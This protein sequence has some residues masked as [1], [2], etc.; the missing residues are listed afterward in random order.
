MVCIDAVAASER[1]ILS[2]T[3][4]IDMPFLFEVWKNPEVLRNFNFA[5]AWK[6]VQEFEVWFEQR[7]IA[8]ETYDFT[9]ISCETGARV[10][11]VGF[12]IFPSI[13]FQRSTDIALII[14]PSCR[15]KGLG[16]AALELA[17]GY[18]LGPMMSD[19]I[20]AGVYEFN[21]VPVLMLEKLGFERTPAIDIVEASKWGTETIVQKTYVLESPHR[22]EIHGD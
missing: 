13:Q 18:A 10:G 15:G 11:W 4:G 14:H 1:V 21:D 7:G 8:Y 12:G 6:S 2:P 19:A 5:P 9:V 22:G 20:T 3:D 16:S 17:V